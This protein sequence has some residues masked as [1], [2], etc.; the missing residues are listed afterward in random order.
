MEIVSG[1]F[2]SKNIVYQ[3]GKPAYLVD[4]GKAFVNELCKDIR[5]L[6]NADK[7]LP[8]DDNLLRYSKSITVSV[9]L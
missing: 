2:I 1:L 4:F 9:T 5:A 6:H 8:E 3:N 7:V